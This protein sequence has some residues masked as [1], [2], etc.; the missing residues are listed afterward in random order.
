MEISLTEALLPGQLTNCSL[1]HGD[2]Y[3]YAVAGLGFVRGLEHRCQLDLL[4]GRA[5]LDR[6][7][8]RGL[9]QRRHAHFDLG[10]GD[11]QNAFNLAVEV[12][13]ERYADIPAVFRIEVARLQ[14]GYLHRQGDN[15]FF[16]QCRVFH[17]LVVGEELYIEG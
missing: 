14:H 9:R 5:E 8:E 6:Q 12:A 16:T 1:S 2:F 10:P 4:R 3:L 15:H 11:V 17:R 13:G 7:L